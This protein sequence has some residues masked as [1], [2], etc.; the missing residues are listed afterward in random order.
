[1]ALDLQQ[2]VLLALETGFPKIAA[3][4]GAPELTSRHGLLAHRYS[5]KTVAQ[6]LVQKA[7]RVVSG[8]HASFALL[9]AGH[10]QELRAVY[11]MLDEFGEEIVFLGDIIVTGNAS[12]L[13]ERFLKD[14]WSEEFDIDGNPLA[15][16]QKRDRL[17][18]SKIQAAIVR[19]GVFPVNPSDGQRI[20]GT[21]ARAY[22]GY[23]HGASPHIME[24]YGGKP[25]RF[26]TS[27]MCGTPPFELAKRESLNYFYRGLLNVTFVAIVV[28]CPEA[29]QDL[30]AAKDRFEKASGIG[31]GN[32][33][34]MIRKLKGGA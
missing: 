1:M 10:L 13:H 2:D 16:S 18:R 3:C 32:A 28:E 22:S 17:S 26:H 34:K 33:E 27:G 21:L 24:M 30:R 11:R 25:E 29:E 14:F 7:A 12:D 4:V 23:V 20:H 5:E 6:A 31:R 8:L 9:S 19:Q 15:S